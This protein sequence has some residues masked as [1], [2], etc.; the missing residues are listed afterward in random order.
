MEQEIEEKEKMKKHLS[1]IR[2][3]SVSGRGDIKTWN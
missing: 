2:K 3:K 1:N